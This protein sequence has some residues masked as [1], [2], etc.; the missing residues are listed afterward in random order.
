MSL[1]I[2]PMKNK[3]ASLP[4]LAGSSCQQY[5]SHSTTSSIILLANITGGTNFLSKIFAFLCRQMCQHA[6]N[7][8]TGALT[9]QS[10]YL[11]LICRNNPS[12]F[13]C[14]DPLTRLILK[15]RVAP[16]LVHTCH[17]Y[18]H[19]N[20]RCVHVSSGQ[21]WHMTQAGLQD[22]LRCI[23]TSCVR[24]FSQNSKK[25]KMQTVSGT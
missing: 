1:S 25:E 23:M 11:Y 15:P 21:S 5:L 20:N 14:S 7:N 22:I 17:A 19:S 24:I 13:S 18:R 3:N 12:H 10:L 4:E 6:H 2:L 16:M 8:I 9:A